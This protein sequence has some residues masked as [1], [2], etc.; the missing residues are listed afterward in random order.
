MLVA[1][2]LAVGC[3]GAISVLHAKGKPTGEGAAELAVKNASGTGIEKLYVAKTDAVDKAREAGASPGS[4]ADQALWGEDRLVSAG[5]A[6]GGMWTGTKLEPANYD[7]LVVA[8]DHR[9]QLVKHLRL[10]GGGHY[11]LEIK[12]DW[13]LGRD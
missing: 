4:A 11:V 9:E 13:M 6:D 2:A 5:I 10:Q 1:A 3:G 12:D 7:V 8:K